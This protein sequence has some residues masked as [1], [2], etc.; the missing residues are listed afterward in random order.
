MVTQDGH[1]S[2][3]NSR[4]C[5]TSKKIVIC[6]DG[7]PKADG[8]KLHENYPIMILPKMSISVS[9]SGVVDTLINYRPLSSHQSGTGIV[10]IMFRKL[11]SFSVCCAL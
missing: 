2:S 3:D 6:L 11:I 8:L 1:W 10:I 4:H 7:S 5:N 9:E